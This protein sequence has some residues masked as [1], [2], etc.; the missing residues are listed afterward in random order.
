M[1]IFEFRKELLLKTYCPTPPNDYII[2]PSLPGGE[3]VT[4]ENDG[5]KKSSTYKGVIIGLDPIIRNFFVK[6]GRDGSLPDY[7]WNVSSRKR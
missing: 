7:R 1:K 2:S 4:I 3:F 5:I 6:N